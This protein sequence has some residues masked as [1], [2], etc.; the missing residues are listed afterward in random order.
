M[1]PGMQP[2]ILS[3]LD[4][5]SLAPHL[6]E[7]G[8]GLTHGLEIIGFVRGGF[9]INQLDFAMMGCPCGLQVGICREICV[10]KRVSLKN[11][12]HARFP[13]VCLNRQWVVS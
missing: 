8:V 10:I 7:S 1:T 13:A 4:L 11:Y 5:R 3:P 9:V 12:R 2:A 6:P